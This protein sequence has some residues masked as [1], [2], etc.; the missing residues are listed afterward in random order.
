MPATKRLSVRGICPSDASALRDLERGAR[1]RWSA[2]ADVKKSKTINLLATL[3]SDFYN[4]MRSQSAWM[5]K[6]PDATIFLSDSY[7]KPSNMKKSICAVTI[8][9]L[10]LKK[11]CVVISIFTTRK[12]PHSALDGQTSE[13]VLL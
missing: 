7:E 9:C 3:L 13:S 11:F 2:C 1:K 10:K 12:R 6:I 5:A 4:T 8:P